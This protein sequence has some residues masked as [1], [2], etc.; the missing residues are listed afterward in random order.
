MVSP[1]LSYR[2]APNWRLQSTAGLFGW[3]SF[4]VACVA[5]SVTAL[6]VY[7]GRLAQKDKVVTTLFIAIGSKPSNF[8]LRDS[9]RRSWLQWASL[10]QT[11]YKFFSDHP[12]YADDS[13]KQHAEKLLFEA[14]AEK[15]MVLMNIEGGYGT[16]EDNNFLDRALYQFEYA[17][18][19]YDFDYFLRVD[20][21]SFLCLH[22]LMFEL[23]SYPSRQFFMGRYV[24]TGAVLRTVITLDLFLWLI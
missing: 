21:D 23:K 22:R 4:F 2:K 5:L 16:K 19:N 3:K 12:Q 1:K 10:G 11:A 7:R 14:K 17:S 13:D 8:H 15:D 6:V 20:D 18:K 24:P 9:A